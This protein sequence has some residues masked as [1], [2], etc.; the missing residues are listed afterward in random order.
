MH[1]KHEYSVDK[2]YISRR[3][4][5][6]L[7]VNEDKQALDVLQ[8]LFKARGHN[9]STA[10]EGGECIAKCMKKNFDLILLGSSING[11][12][13]TELADSIRDILQSQSIIF[14]YTEEK[15]PADI[16][17]FKEVGINGILLKPLNICSINGIVRQI[18]D[19]K[20]D[21]ISTSSVIYL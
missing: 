15:K 8:T 1:Y 21:R 4:L 13:G 10:D 5:E 19:N 11:I 3:K 16:R 7:V 14:A 20:L 17:K 9:V 12:G 2:S 6:I 18:E